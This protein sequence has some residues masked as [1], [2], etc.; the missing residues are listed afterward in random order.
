LGAI[1]FL[2]AQALGAA[3]GG[4]VTGRMMRAVPETEDE[5]FR[6]DVHGLAVWGLAV[7]FGLSLLALAAG[8]GLTAAATSRTA[9][10]PA[11]YWADKLLRPANASQASLAWRQYAQNAVPSGNDAMAQDP[12]SAGMTPAMSV[13]VTPGLTPSYADIR[14][15]ASRLLTAQAVPATADSSDRA[16]LVRLVSLANGAPASTAARKVDSTITDMR[17]AAEKAADAARRA[18]S[19]VSIW[20]ALA[21]LFSAV[22]CVAATI[23]ARWGGHDA[24]TARRSV[25]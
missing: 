4:Y 17:A 22:V 10:P 19:Y 18:A 14:A 6:A 24:F 12:A 1:Y 13:P 20:T 25:D 11:N 15:E 21:L 3:I 9:A 2:A 5:H 16:E 7:V 8:P 23:A